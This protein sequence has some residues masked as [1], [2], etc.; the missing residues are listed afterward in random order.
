[1]KVKQSHYRP[2]QALRVP[3]GWGSQIS[4]QSAHECG[5]VVSLTHRP[6]LPPQINIA[7]THFCHSLSRAKGHSAAGRITSMKN[8]NDIT[9]N[10]TRDLPTCSAVSR[11]TAPPAACPIAI[12]VRQYTKC[13]FGLC[14]GKWDVTSPSAVRLRFTRK[15]QDN[16]FPTSH[17]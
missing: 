5:K 13:V 10:R 8:C 6:P 4:K 11:P 15:V 14:F 17:I 16:F 1:M 9:G 12:S 7:G 2:G 3:A